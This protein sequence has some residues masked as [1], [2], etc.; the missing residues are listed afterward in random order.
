MIPRE[1]PFMQLRATTKCPKCPGEGK[2]GDTR[3]RLISTASKIDP[4][5]GCPSHGCQKCPD[6]KIYA[7]AITDYCAAEPSTTCERPRYKCLIACPI[8]SRC[9]PMEFDRDEVACGCPCLKCPDGKFYSPTRDY[10]AAKAL[11]RRQR[12]QCPNALHPIR[13]SVNLCHKR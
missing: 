8:D 3:C 5:T 9:S 12:Q 11:T 13:P 6:D 7:R 10:M 2:V 4:T 1:N